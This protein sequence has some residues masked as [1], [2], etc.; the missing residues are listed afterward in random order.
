MSSRAHPACA[1]A[2]NARQDLAGLRPA[3]AIGVGHAMD[4]ARHLAYGPHVG[5]VVGGALVAA[6]RD[7]NAGIAEPAER[8]DAAAEL[9]GCRSD[10]ARRHSRA[11]AISAIS[12]SSTQIAWMTITRSS[13]CL[14]SC[15]WRINDLPQRVY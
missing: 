2:R 10:C 5:G 13:R 6:E 1:A 3:C 12:S 7:R 8:H 14:R 9:G 4:Q 15:T 11:S